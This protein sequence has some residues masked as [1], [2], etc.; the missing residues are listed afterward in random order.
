[1]VV[2]M[3]RKPKSRKAA[4][5]PDKV[6][7]APRRPSTSKLRRSD[8]VWIAPR[9]AGRSGFRTVE[10]ADLERSNRYL[11]FADIALGVKDTR[12]RKKKSSSAESQ[13]GRNRNR[14][15]KVTSIDSQGPAKQGFGAF[16]SSR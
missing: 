6:W 11:E 4:A 2:N 3:P 15:S 8:K 9:P 7:I 13:P 16:R 1:V 10:P 14:K 5:S 12:P